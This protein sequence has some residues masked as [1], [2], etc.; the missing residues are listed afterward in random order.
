MTVAKQ[1]TQ[2][3]KLGDLPL[4]LIDKILRNLLICSSSVE[5]V[6]KGRSICY[7]ENKGK[8]SITHDVN[9]VFKT[10]TVFWKEGKKIFF[11]KNSFYV[12]DCTG[13][14]CMNELRS[15]LTAIG[16]C[17]REFIQR[18]DFAWTMLA[19]QHP[20]ES[21]YNK[22][23]TQV[24]QQQFFAMLGTLP[25]LKTLTIYTKLSVVG[26]TVRSD[27]SFPG[28]IRKTPKL[29]ND[30]EGDPKQR[31]VWAEDV[32]GAAELKALPKLTKIVVHGEDVL[33][34]LS[35]REFMIG[36]PIP[37]Y[38]KYDQW[39]SRRHRPV[40]GVCT[41]NKRHMAGRERNSL[42]TTPMIDLEDAEIGL[43]S[44]CLALVLNRGCGEW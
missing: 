39:V 18:L 21:R 3:P 20:T 28:T 10:C 12:R 34:G 8:D 24:T 27:P 40:I 31:R 37:L 42:L 1:T 15:W 33:S 25:N 41:D 30:P 4:E 38:M 29:L 36:T 23:K 19:R 13:K 32:F 14:R 5:P 7:M 6:K 9:S 17:N 26:H 22:F 16:E 43:S 11:S 35:L 44:R 2:G